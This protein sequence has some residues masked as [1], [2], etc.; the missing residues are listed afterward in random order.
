PRRWAHRPSPARSSLR[1]SL[2]HFLRAATQGAKFPGMTRLAALPERGVIEGGGEDRETFLQGLV[3]NDVTQATPGHAVWAAL[4]TP[5]GKWLADFFIVVDDGRL[6]LDCE[7]AQIPLL[8][9]R[10]PRF[11]L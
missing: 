1:R 9:Q 2:Y 7:L 8:L 10:L 3:S 4:L 5:Q 6:L 11:R